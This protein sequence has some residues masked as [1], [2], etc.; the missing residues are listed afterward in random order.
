MASGGEGASDSA[1]LRRCALVAVG[2]VTTSLLPS[3]GAGQPAPASGSKAKKGKKLHITEFLK[4]EGS[5]SNRWADDDLD[6]SNCTPAACR[7]AADL[8]VCPAV[9]IAGLTSFRWPVV[10]GLA[11]LPTAPGERPSYSAGGLSRPAV[12]SRPLPSHPPFKVYI[13]NVPFQA[14]AETMATIFY[15]ELQVWVVCVIVD[16][17]VLRRSSAVTPAVRAG[18]RCVGVAPPRHRQRQRLLCGV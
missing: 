5:K 1:S 3:C 12:P 4:P 7:A 16:T 14:D 11:P 2:A 9:G 6:D 10:D 15:P 13:S 18:E 8:W 17:R